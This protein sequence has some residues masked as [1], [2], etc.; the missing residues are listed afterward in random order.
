MRQPM[1]DS[2]LWTLYER[3]QSE[4]APL[5]M[6]RVEDRSEIFPVFRELFKKRDGQR[7]GAR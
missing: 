2:P 3:L 7:V 4:G 6:R 1:P 5:S